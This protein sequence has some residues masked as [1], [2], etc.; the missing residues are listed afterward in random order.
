[1]NMNKIRILTY[2]EDIR[3][4]E[5][6]TGQKTGV[7]YE[8]K[9]IKLVKDAVEFP[10]GTLGTYIRFVESDISKHGCVILPIIKETHEVI[11]LNHWRHAIQDYCIEAPRGFGTSGVSIEENALKEL[12]EEI[13]ASFDDLTF[14]GGI[15]PDTGLFE[16]EVYVFAALISES[17]LG[18]LKCNDDAEIIDGYQRYTKDDLTFLMAQNKLKDSF[19]LTSVSMAILK[20]LL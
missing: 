18:D 11:L 14:L 9:Y 19:T 16:K 17:N 10:N 1:M 8:D 12:Q 2:Q 4:V 20:G 13:N 15:Y 7:I 5:E 3:K 6:T